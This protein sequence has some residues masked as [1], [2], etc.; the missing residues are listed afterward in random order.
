MQNWNI[1]DLRQK[2][3]PRTSSASSNQLQPVS[4]GGSLNG[5]KQKFTSGLQITSLEVNI[6]TTLK[7]KSEKKMAPVLAHLTFDFF[8]LV[9]ANWV[10]LLEIVNEREL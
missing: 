9:A 6:Y 5:T 3:C 10:L 7:I 1:T 4:V 2:N 8:V